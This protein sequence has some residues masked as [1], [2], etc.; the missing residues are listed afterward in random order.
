ML[1]SI[2]TRRQTGCVLLSMPQ[3]DGVSAAAIAPYFP[4][5]HSPL[6][7]LLRRITCA[8]ATHFSNQLRSFP[9]S[10]APLPTHLRTQLGSL[11]LP[12]YLPGEGPNCRAGF[13]AQILKRPPC[14]LCRLRR[15]RPPWRSSPC[16]TEPACA[17]T[18]ARSRRG[19]QADPPSRPPIRSRSSDE[20]NRSYPQTTCE[21]IPH[22]ARGI[23]SGTSGTILGASAPFGWAGL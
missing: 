20:W 7:C 3:C 6:L 12:P 13:A 2:S 15:T 22:K 14:Y 1:L 9:T 19:R 17:P 23:T 5:A 11:L 21:H 18:A 8:P 10:S 16:R 4:S